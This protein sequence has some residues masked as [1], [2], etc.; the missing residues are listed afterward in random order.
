M[1]SM[2]ACSLQS[3][4]HDH[5]LV[6]LVWYASYVCGRDERGVVAI[7]ALSG[8]CARKVICRKNSECESLIF[9]ICNYFGPCWAKVS[10]WKS[11]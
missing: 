11:R 1:R 9:G 5:A 6:Y 2:D 10:C 4:S 3:R 8:P 7:A